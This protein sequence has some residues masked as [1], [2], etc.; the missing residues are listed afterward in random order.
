MRRFVAL[1]VGFSIGQI[2]AGSAIGWYYVF[3]L[4]KYDPKFSRAPFAAFEIH[5]DLSIVLALVGVAV[6][7]LLL[8][9]RRRRSSGLLLRPLRGA[10]VAVVFGLLSG[11]LHFA[12]L[13]LA[14]R[15]GALAYLFWVPP[16]IC[17]AACVG[18]DAVMSGKVV[19]PA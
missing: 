7:G 10:I 9:L 12:Y 13:E 15:W 16:V 17:A 19:A 1:A 5:R 8:A 6:I 11:S 3:V 18:L 14:N 2:L 4:Q